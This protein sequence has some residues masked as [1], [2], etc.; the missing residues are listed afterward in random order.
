MDAK[1]TSIYHGVVC[2][3]EEFRC[4]L[5]Q[6]RSIHRLR[7]HWH[8]DREGRGGIGGVDEGRFT[9][10]LCTCIRQAAQL[11]NTNNSATLCKGGS[12]IFVNSRERSD[13][14]KTTSL[15]EKTH[16]ENIKYQIYARRSSIIERT[17]ATTM[18]IHCLAACGNHGSDTIA[19]TALRLCVR[20]WPIRKQ[21]S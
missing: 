13:S 2:I 21:I 17:E 6:R 1:A 4:V 12:H 20:A 10:D 18:S 7:E 14:L 19:C 5:R 9:A 11:F 15:N 3:A 16:C 8:R